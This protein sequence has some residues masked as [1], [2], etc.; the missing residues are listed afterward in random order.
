MA[1]KTH[2]VTSPDALNLLG[3]SM[4]QVG[5]RRGIDHYVQVGNKLIEEASRIK[6]EAPEMPKSKQSSK[7]GHGARPRPAR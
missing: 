3:R 6:L 5:G 1:N 2:H 7:R 4:R